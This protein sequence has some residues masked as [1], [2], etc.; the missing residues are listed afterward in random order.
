VRRPRSATPSDNTGTNAHPAAVANGNRILLQANGT[1]TIM[2]RNNTLRGSLG[3]AIAT[4]AATA[5]AAQTLTIQDNDI[6]VAGTA[7]SGSTSASGIS[8]QSTSG[9]DVT[10]LI[11][12]NDIRQYNNHAILFTLGDQ[13]GNPAP[14]INVTVTGNTTNTPGTLLDNFNGFHI[15]SG[16]VSTDNFSACF[17]IQ[18]NNFTG[19]GKGAVSPNNSDVRLRQRQGTTILLPGYTGPARDN[20]DLD[21]AEVITYLRPA[22]SGG[23]KNNI[24]AT[25]NAN[26]VSTGGGFTNTPG[27]AVCIVP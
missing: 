9:G 1:A 20:G 8:I 19:G 23:L 27:G 2:V 12:G 3:S 22:G 24:F 10:G 14:A 13:M 17:N 18:D 5:T 7:N 4:N 15:N 16:T 6:G 21:V 25:G 26:S 11:A